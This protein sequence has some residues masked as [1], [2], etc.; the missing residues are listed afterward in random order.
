MEDLGATGIFFKKNRQLKDFSEETSQ[1]LPLLF[2]HDD[3]IQTLDNSD[4]VDREKLTNI[5]NYLHFMDAH[6]LVLLRHRRFEKIIVAKAYPESCLGEKLT[7]RW[8]GKNFSN[9]RVADYQVLNLIIDDGKTVILV[10]PVMKEIDQSG[11]KLELPETSYSLVQRRVRRYLCQDISGEFIQAGLHAKCKLIDFSPV[12]FRVQFASEFSSALSRLNPDARSII[13]LHKKGRLIFSGACKCIRQKKNYQLMEL[14]LS[15]EEEKILRFKTKQIR[16]PRRHLVPPPIF[17]FKHPFFQKWIALDIIDLS[18]S[19]FAVRENANERCLMPGMIIPDAVIDYAGILKMKCTTQVIYQETESDDKIRLGIALLDIDISTYTHLNHLLVNS[20]DPQAHISTDVVPERLWEFFFDSGFIY[21]T[22]YDQI[23]GY[24]ETF[25]EMYLKLYNGNLDIARHFTYEK[26]GQIDGHISMVRAYER[27]WMIHHHAARAS[28]GKRTGFM[29]LKQIM[30]FLNDMNRFPS[31]DI[32]HVMCYFRP[33]N[34]FPRVVFG[35][36][37]RRFKNPK[38][39]SMDLFSYI[40][41][42]GLSV[43][44]KLPQ[45]WELKSCNAYDYWELTQFYNSRSKGM[46]IDALF[47]DR[48]EPEC[49]PLEEMYD[50]SGFLRKWETY[51]LSHQGELHAVFI[52]NRSNLGLNLSELTNGIK[53]IVTK[54]ESL[55]WDTLSIGV[56]QL[57]GIFR[58]EKVPILIYPFDYVQNQSIPY[59]KKYQLWILDVGYGSEFIDFVQQKFKVAFQ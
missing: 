32:E 20:L 17:K 39:C 23:Q 11:I 54:P 42:P 47:S 28:G 37:A 53:I 34:K 19:G 15:P 38:A 50:K 52:V 29:V 33:E 16:N 3:L 24:K 9:N 21:P 45:G 6:I 8:S 14:V 2:N 5:I 43:G 59:D 27:T 57:T 22:K 36:F 30:H 13:H 18:T 4:F 46:L 48:I 25:K 10:P 1:L 55:S 58:M 26:N 40:S 12:G 31:T 41:Y 56:A 51:A 35:G 49:K 7:C 44:T